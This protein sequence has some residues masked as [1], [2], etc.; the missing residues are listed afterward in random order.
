MLVIVVGTTDVSLIPGISIAGPSPEAT[1]Y[2]P[3]LDVEYLLTGRPITLDRV[4]VT[5]TGIPTPAVVTRAL[6]TDLPKLVVDAG[7]RHPPQIPRVT[8]GGAP[9][10][11]IRKGALPRRAVETIAKN[12]YT[13]GE[14]LGKLGRVAIGES[15][16]GGTT[17]AMAILI[18]LGYNAWGRTSSAAPNN[19]K[20]LKIAIVKEALSRLKT[21]ADPITAVSEVG[22]PVHI[23]IAS[24]A[25]GVVKTGGEVYLAGGTQMA[26]AAALY[27]ALGGDVGKL[28][29]VTTRW[30]VEDKTAD[31]FGLMEEV[32]VKRIYHSTVSFKDSKC[33]GLRA[34]E[35]G[36]VKEGVA[37][38]YALWRAEKLGVE[39]LPR[40]EEELR[41]VAGDTCYT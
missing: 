18:A 33:R 36:Y 3:A 32:G 11:D 10:G 5:P 29:V 40:V 20:E 6:T 15:I 34:Y 27:K 28:A 30:V 4:P 38:G 19:P 24:I 21:P 39:I 16:P 9:G 1:H 17:T 8:L 37:M 7:S 31:F 13:L 41:R 26:A 2:T 23:A 14:Q 25:L 35:E 22:D 12:G